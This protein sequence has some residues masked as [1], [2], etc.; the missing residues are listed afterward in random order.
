MTALNGVEEAEITLTLT[1]NG[2]TDW[3]LDGVHFDVLAFRPNAPRSYELVVVSGDMTTG[4]VFESS[5]EEI[6]HVAGTL[7][8]THDTHD[9][10]DLY[11]TELADRT[12]EVGESATIRITFGGGAGS[13]LGHHLFLDNLAVSGF[14][15]PLS[16]SA[17]EAWREYYF[18]PA[19]ISGTGIAADSYDANF[20]GESNLIEFATGQDPGAGTLASTP[21]T[22]NGGNL[23]F[24]YTRSKAALADGMNFT[25]E[26]SDTLL[27]DSWSA[28]G[29]T[30]TT[31][32]EN[33]GDSEV[34]NR[35][36]TI[37][38]GSA[39]R[40]FVHLKVSNP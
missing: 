12:L 16:L 33:P 29:V 32:P 11:F 40:R 14:T 26:W 23:E 2:P 10:I 17:I 8:G 18:G 3:N 20:D 38:A 37:P 27:P 21:L 22:V 4:S 15:T 28:D 30:E 25:V 39:G 6:N 19:F 35:I 24:R 31:D 7:P 5:A 34:E 36:A 13:A 1:N 9:Q